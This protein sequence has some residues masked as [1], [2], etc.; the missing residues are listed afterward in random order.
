MLATSSLQQHVFNVLQP[1]Y[2][3][4]FH[5]MLQAIQEDLLPL[6]VTMPQADRNVAGGYFIW[7]TLP[8]GLSAEALAERTLS[9]ESL[10]I[11]P[12]PLFK[13]QGEDLGREMKFES[14]LRLCFS[15]L[16]ENLMVEGVRRLAKVLRRVLQGEEP[17]K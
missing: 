15:Y 16:E 2:F 6:G 17:S 13:V 14:D 5:K 7:L 9:E 8:H 12:G 1:A 10:V 11:A 3:R 4:R